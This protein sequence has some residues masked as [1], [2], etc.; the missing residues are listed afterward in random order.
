[1]LAIASMPFIARFNM[2]YCL[3]LIGVCWQ[4]LLD[5]QSRAA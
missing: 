3:D 2:A 4:W 5:A 1:M